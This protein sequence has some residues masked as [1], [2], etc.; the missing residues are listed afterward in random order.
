[1]RFPLAV[2]AA[3]RE[4]AARGRRS[5]TGS[6]ALDLVPGGADADEALELARRLAAAG[7]VDALNVGIG[8]HESRVPTVQARGAPRRLAPWARAVREAVAGGAGDRVEPG[9]HGGARR[10]A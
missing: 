10:R 1:M 4:A 7:A 2:A 5:C 6:P 8:W 9:Q 3:V